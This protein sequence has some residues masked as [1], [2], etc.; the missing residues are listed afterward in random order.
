MKEQLIKIE[1]VGF[2]EELY[3]RTRYDWFT[4]ND[5]KNSMMTGAVFPPIEVAL[6]NGKFYLIDGRHRIEAKKLLKEEHIQAIVHTN[7]SIKKIFEKAIEL[8]IIHGRPLSFQDKIM[9]IDKLEKLNFTMNDIV[10]LIGMPQ[11]KIEQFKI[12]RI[13]NTIS[14]E[15]IILKATTK[16][17]AGQDVPNDFNEHQDIYSTR[18]QLSLLRQTISLFQDGMVDFNNKE[19]TKEVV[20]LKSIIKS[21]KIPLIK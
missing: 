10:R 8:N 1:Q 6:L 21:I 7:L 19:I 14:G 13:T 11:N 3:P 20:K 5:Y 18:G 17:F 9:V 4:A 2:D 12:E 16:N 15:T